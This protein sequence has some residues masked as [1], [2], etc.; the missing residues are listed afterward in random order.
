MKNLQGS[1]YSLNKS[2]RLVVRINCIKKYVLKVCFLKI[3]YFKFLWQYD[4][5]NIS[6]SMFRD[7]W[8]FV[9]RYFL[10]KKSPSKFTLGLKVDLTLSN[11]GIFFFFC[12]F[13]PK[14]NISCLA[15]YMRNRRWSSPSSVNTNLVSFTQHAP[16]YSCFSCS[17]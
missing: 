12:W 3:N 7:I 14:S 16:Y 10:C 5:Q 17:I 9:F 11:S 4:E 2:S 8:S 6:V 1:K 15:D 13:L